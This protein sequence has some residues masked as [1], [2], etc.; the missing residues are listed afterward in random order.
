MKVK[1]IQTQLIITPWSAFKQCRQITNST[2]DQCKLRAIIA[3]R[4][5][6]NLD[7]SLQIPR[8][9]FLHP[10][11]IGTN[12]VKWMVRGG[13]DQLCLPQHVLN[14]TVCQR[15]LPC[16]IYLAGYFDNIWQTFFHSALW[17][18][19]NITEH[20]NKLYKIESTVCTKNKSS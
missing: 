13:Q 10:N 15:R 1:R 18:F 8:K 12:F 11:G 4:I 5:R 9:L 6:E 3:L 20:W 7:L 19:H 14:V 2:I 16:A 17:S